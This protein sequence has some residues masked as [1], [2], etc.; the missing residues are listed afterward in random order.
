MDRLLRASEGRD[1]GDVLKKSA[2]LYR[3]ILV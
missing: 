1:V 2:L 3:E